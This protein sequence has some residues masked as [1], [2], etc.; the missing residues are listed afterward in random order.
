MPMCEPIEVPSFQKARGNATTMLH[1][2]MLGY[3]KDD[4]RVL[5]STYGSGSFWSKYRPALLATNDLDPGSAAE[6]H[7]DFRTLAQLLPVKFEVVVFDPP[8]KLNGTPSGPMDYRYGVGISARWQDRMALCEQGIVALAPLASRHLF[9]KCMDQVVSGQVR[10]QSRIFADVAEAQGFVLE[11]MLLVPSGRPQPTGRTQ[12]HS[13]RNYS[14]LLV[15]R[16]TQP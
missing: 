1:C 5:D 13:R 3:L 4:D 16:R 9:I 6:M 12:K 10:W 11:D 15:L 2:R 14:N 7:H 8:Y